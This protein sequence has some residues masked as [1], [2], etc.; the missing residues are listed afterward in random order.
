MTRTTQI[1]H[2]LTR[3]HRGGLMALT[4][5]V[6]GLPMLA[7]APAFADHNRSTTV[8]VTNGGFGFSYHD[9]RCA[10]PPPPPSWAQREF[11]RGQCDGRTDGA[12]EGYSDGL[13][14]CFDLRIRLDFCRLSRPF[15]DGYRSTY[16]QAYSDAFQR[17][18]CE[19]QAR[20]ERERCERERCE[21]ERHFDHG[22]AWGVWWRR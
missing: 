14:D 7:A 5:A 9:A 21:R 15:E 12:R 4:A 8:V 3:C 1:T 16:K 10:P 13:R 17:G 2:T 6:A 22:P 18:R 19:L 20:L 11:E